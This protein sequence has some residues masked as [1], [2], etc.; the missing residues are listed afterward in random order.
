MV[1]LFAMGWNKLP[2]FVSPVPDPLAWA[3]DALSLNWEGLG[4]YAFPPTVLL[5][6][7]LAKIQGTNVSILLVASLN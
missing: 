2:T 5:P 1:D 7:V 3:V 6:K 4:A